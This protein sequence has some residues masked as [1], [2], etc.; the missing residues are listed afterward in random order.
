MKTLY[1]VEEKYPHLGNAM[2]GIFFPGKLRNNEEIVWN[3]LA[4]DGEATKRAATYRDQGRWH[5]AEELEGQ[6]MEALNKE[7]G[8]NHHLMLTSI[9]N[10]ASTYRNQGRKDIAEKLNVQV[11]DSW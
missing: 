8:A 10:L 5:N 9:A 6:L 2:L 11:T 1:A 4:G 3:H 7:L